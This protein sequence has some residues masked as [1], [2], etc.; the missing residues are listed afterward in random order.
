MSEDFIRRR[1]TRS[2]NQEDKEELG[3]LGRTHKALKH[4]LGRQVRRLVLLG[5]VLLWPLLV[6]GRLTASSLQVVQSQLVAQADGTPPE[7]DHR[8]NADEKSDGGEIN[9]AELFNDAFLHTQP[10]ELGVL[11]GMPFYNLQVAQIV[12]LLVMLLIFLKLRGDLAKESKGQRMGRMSRIFSGWVLFIRDEM[13]LPI[14]GDADTKRFLPYFLFVFFFIVIQN[15]LGLIALDWISP[16]ISQYGF[17]GA[18]A[19]GCVFVTGALAMTTFVFMV[20]SG[21]KA[22][23]AFAF[24][25]NLVPHGVPGWLVPLMFV[26]E[27][28]G[29]IV[30]PF[31]LMIRLFANMLAGHLVLFS[32]ITLIVLFGKMMGNTA[33][34]IVPAPLGLGVFI[35]IIEGFVSLLQAYIFTYLSI[36]FVGMCRHPEH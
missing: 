24:W 30:K 21:M 3:S 27:L 28:I 8:V 11:F 16:S 17:F 32:F 4:P 33:W 35:M 34:L 23:G 19:T 7:P 22:Q 6:A 9:P 29:L 18:T 20:G 2:P 1:V 5:V 10:H 36:L 25:K 26:V 14:L 31:A 12:A 13:V 15:L